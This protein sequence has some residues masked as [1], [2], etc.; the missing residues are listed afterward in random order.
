MNRNDM[1][2]IFQISFKVA[3]ADRVI[4]GYEKEILERF[5]EVL[6]INDLQ[7]AEILDENIS[8]ESAI[9]NLSDQKSQEML[10]KTMCALAFADGVRYEEEITMVQKA[11]EQ[12]N[13]PLDLIPWEHWEHYVEETSDALKYWKP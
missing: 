4:E 10:I 2:L 9:R 3:K 12:I 5:K 13:T 11:N 6:E 7:A 8:I 1:K